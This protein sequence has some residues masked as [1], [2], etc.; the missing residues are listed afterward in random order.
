LFRQELCSQFGD[1][2]IDVDCDFTFGFYKGKWVRNSRDFEE[3]ITSLQTKTLTLWCEGRN[4]K[5]RK[6]SK[7]RDSSASDEEP[8]KTRKKKRKSSYEDTIDR[9]DDIVDDL[10]DK[11]KQ[12]YSNLQYRV[13][14]ETI[15]CGRHSSLENPPRESFYGTQRSCY[16]LIIHL[17]MKTAYL[18]L[19]H[20]L[21]LW[22]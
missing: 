19:S 7:S 14:A 5:H 22:S 15:V 2:L 4:K 16:H 18:K 3:L 1:K 11:H 20:L 8:P 13:W 17:L 21:R 10:K 6:H 9:V 12:K